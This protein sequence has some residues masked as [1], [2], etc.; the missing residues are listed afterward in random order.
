MHEQFWTATARHADLV[1]PATT[2]LERDDLG[3]ARQDTALI[4][5]HRVAAP[6]GEARSDYAIFSRARRA[7]RR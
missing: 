7:A 3:A 1:L 4:A 2:T 6:L 5:M